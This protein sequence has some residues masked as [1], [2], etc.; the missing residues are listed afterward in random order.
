MGWSAHHGKEMILNEAKVKNALQNKKWTFK[1]LYERINVKYELDLKYRGFMNTIKNKNQW[2]LIYAY[3]IADL[4]EVPV[5][6]LFEVKEVESDELN[7]TT[8]SE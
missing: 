4:L 6:E 8:T 5:E 3:A 7:K 1:E 2:K